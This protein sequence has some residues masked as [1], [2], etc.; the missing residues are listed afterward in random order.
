MHNSTAKV[1]IVIP[2]FNR[3]N[4]LENCILSC[5]NQTIK[6]EIIVCDHGSSDNTQQL[7]DKYHDKVI[8]IRKEIDYGIHFNW[9]DAII[10]ATNDLIHLN[11][12]DDWIAPTFIEECLLLMNDTVG[13]CF[14]NV[15]MYIQESNSYKYNIIKL[16]LETGIHSSAL[17]RKYSYKNVLSPGAGLFRKKIL[18]DSLFVGNLPFSKDVYR[19]VGPDLLFS[20][21]ASENYEKFAFVNKPL[22]FFRS[23]DS[24]ISIEASKLELTKNRIKKVYD[25]TAIFYM[26]L[27]FVHR[28]NLI[29][30]FQ[31]N[32]FIVQYFTKKA[33]KLYIIKKL[34]G[35]NL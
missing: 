6:C 33:F 32:L 15:N 18:L 16:G 28:S 35:F 4:Y 17:L 22:A 14:S 5:L 3:A 34:K 25:E 10:S 23:H 11:F 8:Y 13:C 21:M 27:R 20:L 12:D 26:I 9:L 31:L 7:M 1:S 19:G 29:L 30:L 24:S 2:T